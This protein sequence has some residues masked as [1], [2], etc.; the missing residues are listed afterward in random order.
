MARLSQYVH[1]RDTRMFSLLERPDR[2]R[3]RI[4]VLTDSLRLWKAGITSL[5][6]AVSNVKFKL[7]RLMSKPTAPGVA[8]VEMPGIGIPGLLV[9]L[10]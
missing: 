2:N 1:M 3:F 6:V 8:R 5:M 4:F 10:C 7:A 9:H